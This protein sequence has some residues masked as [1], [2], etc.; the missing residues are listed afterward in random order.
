MRICTIDGPFAPVEE[1]QGAHV[2]LEHNI[3]QNR[4]KTRIGLK[5]H[6]NSDRLDTWPD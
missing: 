6:K 1:G 5:S 4:M 3:T 2:S